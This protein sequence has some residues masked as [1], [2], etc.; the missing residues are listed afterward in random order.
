MHRWI[1]SSVQQRAAFD[2][3]D[4][5][6]I[7]HADRL[8]FYTIDFILINNTHYCILGV[9][10]QRC[11]LLVNMMTSFLRIIGES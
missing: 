1:R 2:I 9:I 7:E 4:L 3:H 5:N 8:T 11:L 10:F 6:P